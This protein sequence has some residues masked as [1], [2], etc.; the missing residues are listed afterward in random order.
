M[1]S[2]LPL[3]LSRVRN[4]EYCP[5]CEMA[6]GARLMLQRILKRMIFLFVEDGLNN[7]TPFHTKERLES[8]LALFLISSASGKQNIVSP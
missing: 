3:A 8:A 6:S 4:L 1:L 2:L 7:N 5:E